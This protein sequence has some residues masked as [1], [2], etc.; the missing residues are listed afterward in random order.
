MAATDT[1]SIYDMS[2]EDMIS[3]AETELINDMFSKG[4]ESYMKCESQFYIG[5]KNSTGKT[6]YFPIAKR[7]P[8]CVNCGIAHDKH[9][10]ITWCD[11]KQ[12]KRKKTKAKK[13]VRNP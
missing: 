8:P 13:S 3:K 12:P 7:A 10:M 9:H 6:Q 5:Y 2:V 1:N 4:R 11:Y